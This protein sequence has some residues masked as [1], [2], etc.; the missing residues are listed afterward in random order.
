L[1]KSSFAKIDAAKFKTN[2]EVTAIIWSQGENDGTALGEGTLQKYDYELS[3]IKLI[4][5]YREKYGKNIPFVIVETGRHATCKN[6]D[7][8]FEIVRGVQRKVAND[9]KNVFIGYDKTE[10]FIEKSMLKDAV[11][12]NQD[13]LNEIGKELANF[14][15]DNNIK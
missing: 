9:M 15:L 7:F 8:G 14:L 13:A 12:Y 11:H 2:L 3:L 6:C 1:L 4:N 10:F 5:S